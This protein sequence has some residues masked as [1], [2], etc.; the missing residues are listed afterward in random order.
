[1]QVRRCAVFLIDDTRERLV[2]RAVNDQN[3]IHADVSVAVPLD[4]RPHVLQAIES[5][6]PIHVPD[7][8]VDEKLR[9]FWD[10]ARELGIRTQLAVPLIS[11]QRVIGAISISR[12]PSEPPFLQRE[13][14]L[15]Q[16]IAHQAANAIENARLYEETQRRAE[17]L[18]LVN[19]VSNEMGAVLD[20]DLLVW[21]VIRLIRET[22]DCYHVAI[23]LIEDGE[24]VFRSGINYLQQPMP[25]RHL[26]LTGEGQAIPG[27]VARLGQSILA[28]DVSQDPYY[29]VWPG[30]ENTRSELAVPLRVPGRMQRNTES[31]N[32]II[33]VLDLRS[34]RAGAF[35]Q[36]D[37]DLLNVL[38]AQVAVAIQN[39]RLFGRLHEERATLEA[40][41]DGTDDA[42]IVTDT[43]DR[44]LFFNPAARGALLNGQTL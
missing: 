12:E 23:G 4:E 41:I 22:L 32:R 20:V 30:L 11:K 19:M 44:I 39:A 31:T 2:L 5:R 36:E 16:T 1:M 38:A 21:E 14:D 8:F 3:G 9:S 34:T 27:R 24:L 13:I 10:R 33:G 25:S 43:E 7:V 26:S 40:I 29:E 6:R 17:R 28:P 18:W 42:I 15:C 37:S 35:T